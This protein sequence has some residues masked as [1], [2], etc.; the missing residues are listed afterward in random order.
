[1]PCWALLPARD[2]AWWARADGRLIEVERF[3]PHDG[4]MNIPAAEPGCAGRELADA[5]V[6]TG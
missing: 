3:V 2:G 5:L 1:V 6:R 4:R